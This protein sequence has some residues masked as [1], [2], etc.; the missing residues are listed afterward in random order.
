MMI[1]PPLPL[2][3]TPGPPPQ[4]IANPTVHPQPPQYNNPTPTPTNPPVNQH[5][6][7]HDSSP[8][9]LT[10]TSTTKL[11]HSPVH[12]SLQNFGHFPLQP[13]PHDQHRR[14][15]PRPVNLFP[16]PTYSLSIPHHGPTT[17]VPIPPSY[18]ILR[19]GKNSVAV[20][21]NACQ[22]IVTKHQTKMQGSKQKR[23]NM[24]N[25]WKQKMTTH[26]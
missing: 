4:P 24:K 22:N 7:P 13:L 20:S 14:F 5:A 9:H 8:T 19:A 10:H 23:K 18:M 16:S 3:P 1:Q 12:A 21:L 2:I 15:P 25:D 11:P 17:L 26:P 6:T